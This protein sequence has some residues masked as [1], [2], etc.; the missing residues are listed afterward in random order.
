MEVMSSLAQVTFSWERA[1]LD[2]LDLPGDPDTRRMT[3]D[4]RQ[5]STEPEAAPWNPAWF[6]FT[7]LV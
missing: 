3:A 7:L 4:E 6:A 1:R 2:R 5:S